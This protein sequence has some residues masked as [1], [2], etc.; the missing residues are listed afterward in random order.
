MQDFIEPRENLI[1]RLNTSTTVGLTDQVAA[2]N[3]TLYGS[4]TLTREKPESLAKRIWISA[5]EPM[6][7]MLFIA[8]II[9]IVVNI[10]RGNTGGE[11]DYLECIG[12]FTAITLS[13]FITVAMEGK[14]AKAFEQE[15]SNELSTHYSFLVFIRRPDFPTRLNPAFPG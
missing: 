10:V 5:K 11:A 8:G 1:K 6:I 4:N 3:K 13:V 15:T 7:L 9:T 12:I 14:S 2:Q